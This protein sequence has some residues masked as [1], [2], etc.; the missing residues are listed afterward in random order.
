MGTFASTCFLSWSS[1]GVQCR[2]I[3]DALLSLFSIKKQ[4]DALPKENDRGSLIQ[5]TKEQPN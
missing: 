1:L 5:A 4:V 3:Y 2:K